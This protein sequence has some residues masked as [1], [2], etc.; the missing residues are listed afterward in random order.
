MARYTGPKSRSFL[1]KVNLKLYVFS[2]DDNHYVEV[3][4]R[5]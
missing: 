2:E 5:Q 4:L 1:L 3:E